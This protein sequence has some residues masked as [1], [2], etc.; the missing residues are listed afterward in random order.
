LEDAC[1]NSNHLVLQ[2][3]IRII[4]QLWFLI[5]DDLRDFSDLPILDELPALVLKIEILP[6]LVSAD[7]VK[8]LV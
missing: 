6:N 1:A 5:L 3:A 4:I 7:K 2:H 8:L